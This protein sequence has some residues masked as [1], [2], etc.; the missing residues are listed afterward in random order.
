MTVAD[1]VESVN[2]GSGR[3]EALA[4]GGLLADLVKQGL[5]VNPGSCIHS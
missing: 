2:D 5:L 3:E 4:G 1:F